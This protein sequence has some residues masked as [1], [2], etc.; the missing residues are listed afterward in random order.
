M[1]CSRIAFV[2]V[3]VASASSLSALARGAAETPAALQAEKT[4]SMAAEDASATKTGGTRAGGVRLVVGVRKMTLQ[5]RDIGLDQLSDV[6]QRFPDLAQSTLELAIASDDDFSAHNM[7]VATSQVTQIVHQLG[8]KEL[9]EVGR[10]PY[11][12]FG[13]VRLEGPSTATDPT[14]APLSLGMGDKPVAITTEWVQFEGNGERMI[15]AT[16]HGTLLSS[17]NS[18]WLLSIDLRDGQGTL[19]AQASAVQDSSGASDEPPV[20]APFDAR[21][22]FRPAHGQTFA[23]EFPVRFVL[24]IE[25]LPLTTKKMVDPPASEPNASTQV[26]R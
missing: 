17:P 19:V 23:T 18:R 22:V 25:Q 4:R 9:V 10:C 16:L 8:M 6:L 14:S 15:I 13:T 26:G 5:G 12:A 2:F 3:L 24:S 1:S 11:G 7:G 20:A 21:M